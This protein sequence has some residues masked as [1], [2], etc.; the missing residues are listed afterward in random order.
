MMTDTTKEITDTAKVGKKGH[1]RFPEALGREPPKKIVPVLEDGT[2]DY[3]HPGLTPE[4]IEG[5]EGK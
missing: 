1:P 3:S 4:E 2:P 5:L